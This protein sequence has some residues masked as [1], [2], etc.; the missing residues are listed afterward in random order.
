[1][2]ELLCELI[3]DEI[4]RAAGLAIKNVVKAGVALN[5]VT[6]GASNHVTLGASPHHHVDVTLGGSPHDHLG[7]EED[8]DD[9]EGEGEGEGEGEATRRDKEG[10]LTKDASAA[11]VTLYRLRDYVDDILY[12]LVR[13]LHHLRCGGVA[14]QQRLMQRLVTVLAA[15]LS[16]H[17]RIEKERYQGLGKSDVSSKGRYLALVLDGEVVFLLETLKCFTARVPNDR[18]A[19]AA[20]N[21]A[22]LA[23]GRVQCVREHASCL[24]VL[25]CL[26]AIPNNHRCPS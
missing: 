10:D 20:A 17:I 1:M 19:E 14:V 13:A 7:E 12:M 16:H 22:D 25:S 18:N 24:V 4:V 15:A 3:E 23:L 11:G 5:D 9:A 6:L 21:A 26:V 8:P 2:S